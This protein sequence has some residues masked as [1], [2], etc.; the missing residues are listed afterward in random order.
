MQNISVLVAI[1]V[2]QDGYREI[3]GV[4]EGLREDRESWSNF[5]RY[6][7]ERG[8]KGVQ[9]MISDK[10]P[11]LYSDT[12]FFFLPQNGSVAS[13]NGIATPLRCVRKSI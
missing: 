9:L 1:G 2:N 6:L 7:K 10:C 3:L 13:F 11:G 8:R 4:S 12:G 5:L